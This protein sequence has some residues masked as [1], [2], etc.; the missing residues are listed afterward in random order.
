MSNPSDSS[1]GGGLSPTVELRRFNAKYQKVRPSPHALSTLHTCLT[2][3]EKCLTRLQ[4]LRFVFSLNQVPQE[5][6]LDSEET[7]EHNY[8]QIKGH[9]KLGK[10]SSHSE[11]DLTKL[12][13]RNN[14]N[15]E[16]K[17]ASISTTA[18]ALALPEQ[19]S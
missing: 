9:M 13:A 8:L 14:N 11:K 17:R 6:T 7:E 19:V 2:M 12:L 15:L 5:D 4:V 10:K 16:A 18:Q 1:W 3:Q